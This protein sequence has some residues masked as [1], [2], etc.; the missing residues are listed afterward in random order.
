MCLF[1]YSTEN[2]I[3]LKYVSET[4]ILLKNGCS[5]DVVDILLENKNEGD[6]GEDVRT[7]SCLYPHPIF[8]QASKSVPV[9]DITKSLKDLNNETNRIYKSAH[10]FLLPKSNPEDND[11]LEE[12]KKLDDSSEPW[13]IPFPSRT[14]NKIDILTGTIPNDEF[15]IKTLSE[16]SDQKNQEILSLLGFEWFQIDLSKPI[17]SGEQQWIRLRLK[18]GYTARNKVNWKQRFL[19]SIIGRLYYFY[20]IMGPNYVLERFRNSVNSAFLASKIHNDYTQDENQQNDVIII[21]KFKKDMDDLSNGILFNFEKSKENVIINDWNIYLFPRAL[22]R[23]SSIFLDGSIRQFGDFPRFLSSN[24]EYCLESV[25]QWKTGMKSFPGYNEQQF[26]FRIDFE[27]N[28]VRAYIYVFL[29]LF[30]FCLSG[31]IYFI[32]SLF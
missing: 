2:A 15:R 14:G 32:F 20:S 1:I 8:D 9:E 30:I 16:C 18:P 27:V 4:I 29:F 26:D 22:G 12:E 7:L 6:A 10:D 19:Y 25:F 13:S 3:E 24:G 17:R 21:E 11:K 31:S 23:I 5:Q 28:Y